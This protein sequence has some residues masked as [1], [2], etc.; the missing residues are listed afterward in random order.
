DFQSQTG[1]TSPDPRIRESKKASAQ[2]GSTGFS[3]DA[4]VAITDSAP[5]ENPPAQGSVDEPPAIVNATPSLQ[6]Q[7]Q[8]DEEAQE[9]A[10]LATE[11]QEKSQLPEGAVSVTS[12]T[13][14]SI[15]VPPELEGDTSS[16][17][18]SLQIGEPISRA[19]PVYPEQAKREGV[20]G[21][22]NL[23]AMIGTNGEVQNVEVMSGPALLSAAS[24]SAVRQWRY[25]QTLL[26]DQ[27][28][29]VAVDVAI[30]FRLK[31]PTTGVN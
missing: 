7:D 10:S 20:E 24:V 31:N 25:Q 27:P 8:P 11:P 17:G 5:A 22:V 19:D 29:E 21:T 13:Y 16:S 23:R 14:P 4:A 15:R 9:G 12:S 26:G 6:P 18:A 2:K 28:I 30:V 1:H 3:S